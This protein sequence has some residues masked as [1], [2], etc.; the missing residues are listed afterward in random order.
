MLPS[1]PKGPDLFHRPGNSPRWR[2]HEGD[3]GLNPSL[4][5]FP[6]DVMK[7]GL[8]GTESAVVPLVEGSVG[9]LEDG[10]EGGTVDNEEIV[11]AEAAPPEGNQTSYHFR[12]V[13]GALF[14]A[15]ARWE[16]PDDWEA[17]CVGGVVVVLTLT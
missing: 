1:V 17:H 8:Q 4:G 15:I 9:F 16:A 2:N 7:S 13:D 6:H 11:R 5:Q 14:V 10:E 3:P 12:S